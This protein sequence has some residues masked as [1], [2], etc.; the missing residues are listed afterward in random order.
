M[1]SLKI[2]Q[3]NTKIFDNFQCD[4]IYSKLERMMTKT[5]CPEENNLKSFVRKN[6]LLTS[7]KLFYDS[8]R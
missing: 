5:I 4:F 1:I 3:R 2:F 7:I 8:T 6:S